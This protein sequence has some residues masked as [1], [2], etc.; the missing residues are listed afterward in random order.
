MPS[1]AV[2]LCSL[3]LSTPQAC[4]AA[5]RISLLGHG[6]HVVRAAA[7]RDAAQVVEFQPIRYRT[8]KEFVDNPMD[9][10]LGGCSARPANAGIAPL[11][12]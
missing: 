2:S 11:I 3:V 4:G 6:L 10:S 9:D 8:D 1:R 12:D 7:G 5:L